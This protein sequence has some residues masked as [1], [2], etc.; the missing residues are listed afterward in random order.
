LESTNVPSKSKK[1]P[2]IFNRFSFIR[3]SLAL[4]MAFIS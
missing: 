2:F 4:R 3:L 1:M